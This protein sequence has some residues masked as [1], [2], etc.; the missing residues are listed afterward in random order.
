MFEIKWKYIFNR[1]IAAFSI[2]FFLQIQLIFCFKP[3]LV[4]KF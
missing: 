2:S 4:F 1:F 3:S